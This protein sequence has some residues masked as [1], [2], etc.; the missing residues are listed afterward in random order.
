MAERIRREYGR[1]A[2]GIAADVTSPQNVQ[3]M[4]DR[5]LKEFD[6]VD[7]LIN[8]AGINIRGP[9]DELTYEQF[10]QVQQINVDGVWLCAERSCRT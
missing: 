7:I 2:I 5:A 8:N 6:R 10:Q 4:V 9:I 1:K 3:A